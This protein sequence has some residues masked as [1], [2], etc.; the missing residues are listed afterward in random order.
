MDKTKEKEIEKLIEEGIEKELREKGYSQIMPSRTGYGKQLNRIERM[1]KWLVIDSMIVDEEC[2]S[3]T[4]K[5][6]ELKDQLPDVSDI[7][8]G[9]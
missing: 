8:E 6:N 1:L 9:K 7:I 5:G 3:H 4:N 2:L